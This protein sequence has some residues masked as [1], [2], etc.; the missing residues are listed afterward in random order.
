MPRTHY[1]D[2]EIARDTVDSTLTV[3]AFDRHDN[4]LVKEEGPAD[5]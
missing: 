3:R 4:K 5:V 1:Q 2:T